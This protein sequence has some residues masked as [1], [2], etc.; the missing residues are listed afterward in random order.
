[1][2]AERLSKPS[3][4]MMAETSTMQR[5]TL[6]KPL[7]LGLRTAVI[8]ELVSPE[9]VSYYKQRRLVTLL[10]FHCQFSSLLVFPCLSLLAP[11]VLYCN[12]QVYFT[13]LGTGFVASR[14]P[15]RTNRKQSQG[16]SFS[17]M[18]YMVMTGTVMFHVS[19]C[20]F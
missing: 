3:S 19:F 17:G 20:R 7:L 14:R 5:K 10:N 2:S 18:I 6:P 13:A 8:R 16:T 1:M 12:L 9:D 11:F 15:R 4:G